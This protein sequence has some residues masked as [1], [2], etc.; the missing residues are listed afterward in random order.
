MPPDLV[1]AL[2]TP[3]SAPPNSA[4]MP[5]VFTCTSHVLEHRV[6]A[7][8]AVE[9]AVEG[10]AVHGEG[11]LRGAGTDLI[12][13]YGPSTRSRS[14][15]W[16]RHLPTSVFPLRNR[17]IRST[18]FT[19][20]MSRRWCGYPSNQIRLYS[21]RS[22]WSSHNGGWNIRPDDVPR[23]YSGLPIRTRCHR[24]EANRRT[25]AEP[26]FAADGGGNMLSVN[27]TRRG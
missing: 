18:S 22:R 14:Y 3:P 20:A 4:S 9:E 17:I 19:S 23:H 15:I 27:M 8:V 10:D 11:V 6:L 16:W 13:G 21:P 12:R 25:T 2:I 1:T 26:A 5:P 7:R 24:I